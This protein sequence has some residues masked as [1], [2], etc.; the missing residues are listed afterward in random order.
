MAVGLEFCLLGPLVVR[1]HGLA[2]PVPGG[3]P[4]AVLAAL[5]LDAGELVTVDQLAEVL[6]GADPPPSARVSVQNHIKR[7]RQA[8]GEAG[9]TRI[10]TRPGGYVMCLQAGELDVSRFQNWLARAQA[11]ARDRRWEQASAQASAALLLWRGE[12]LADAGSDL[13]AQRAVPYLAEIRLQAWETR[14]E[15]EV[16]LGR[17]ADAIVDLR[18]LAAM[19]PLREHLHA[20]LMLAL[21]RC[22]RQ[23]EALAAYQAARRIL[24][25]ELGAEP[26]PELRQMHRQIL[27]GDTDAVAAPEPLPP[28]PGT[29]R[30]VVPQQL[31][32]P[33]ADRWIKERILAGDASLLASPEPAAA[34]RRPAV[35]V[36]AAPDVPRELPVAVP[37][38]LPAAI[39]CFTGRDAELAALAGLLEVRPGVRAPALV[40][41]AIGGTAGVG[42]TALAIQWAHL[43]ADRFPDGQLYVNLRGYDRDQPVAAADALAGFLRSLG[44]PGQ[45]IPDGAEDRARLYRSRLAG[46]RVLVLLDNARDGEH[47]RPLLPGDSGCAA[48]VTSRDALAGLVAADGARRLD[49]DVLPLADA[50]AL[51]RSLIG[52]RADQEPAAM[53]TLAGLCARLPLALRI[54]AEQA[55][56]R[57]KVPLAGLVA[58]LTASRLD[59][60]DAGEDRADVRA[61][62]SWSCR[63]LA[64]EVAGAFALAGLHPGD[65]LDGDAAAALTGT[66]TRQARR[67]LGRLHRASLLQAAGPG[68]YGMHDLLRAYAR[69]QAAARDSGG[70]C[71]QALTRLF[72][73]YLA[74][75][76]AAMNILYPAEGH[77]R[78]RIPASATAAPAMPGEAD[79]RAWLDTERANLVS[80]TAHCAG[81]GWTRHAIGLA[82][83]LFRYLISG[84]HLPEA[85]TIYRNALHAARLCGDLAAE[86]EALNGLGGIAVMKGHFR[87]AAD[88]YQAAL[89]RYRRCSDR[90]GQGR[91]LHNLGIT[92]YQL[93]NLRS[94]V[95][96]YRRAITAYEDTGDS[97]GAA[98]ALADLAAAETELGSYDQATEHLRR[99]LPVFRAEKDQLFE[100]EAVSRMGDLSFRRG[101]LT[102]AAAFYEQALTASRRIDHPAGVADGLHSLGEVS[103]RHGDYQHAV[104]HLSQALALYRQNGNQHGEIITLRSLAEGLHGAGQPDAARAELATALRLA[105]DTGNTYHQATAH[106]DLADSHHSV[107]QDEQARHHWQQAL[108]LY[109]QLGA[110]E[111][112]QVRSRLRTQEAKAQR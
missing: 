55:A 102:Q 109:T 75:A 59:C 49:L 90:A 2:V 43:V 83:T 68:R 32:V 17:H 82:A 1:R 62:F 107:G 19:H 27:A 84:S 60:L 112:D 48:V 67:V 103:L 50:V 37:R 66:S 63:Q 4:R 70:Q 108:A 47:V 94:A 100:V 54:T 72:D 110:P 8:L 23:G 80:V 44:V 12:P 42:K 61:V 14:L 92:G 11:A 26:G 6:W 34:S 91:A 18:R 64:E 29:R 79:A 52:P 35:T 30:A 78:P 10:A 87:A 81:H 73:Y 25:D 65:V 98:R 111:A 46:R 20:L 93:H 39:G 53:A 3:K 106:R 89:E 74:A 15:A 40:I 31:L 36:A 24:I 22:G 85:H 57:P 105:A 38:Q 21:V 77:R 71:Q 95:G 41:S 99:A 96:Y 16:Q 9:R 69:E 58:E 104:D 7:L 76:A 101:Q 56:A 5:L 86:A 97:L 13:L 88:H 51:L 33:G 45:E 28:A